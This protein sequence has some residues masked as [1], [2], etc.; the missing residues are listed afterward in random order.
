LRGNF[1]FAC[2]RPKHQHEEDGRT[3]YEMS[4]NAFGVFL[5][6]AIVQKVG[7]ECRKTSNCCVKQG[8][9]TK[10][11]RGGDLYLY[12]GACIKKAAVVACFDT[13]RL[14]M[15]TGNPRVEIYRPVPDP[16]SNPTRL[17]GYGFWSGSAQTSPYPARTRTRDGF[18]RDRVQT[19]RRERRA[20]VK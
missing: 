14:V 16:W 2:Q 6:G 15:T 17:S 3:E 20:H 19:R 18:C 12:N 11:V 13:R 9:R 7:L 10:E 4:T 5:R 1:T 8:A